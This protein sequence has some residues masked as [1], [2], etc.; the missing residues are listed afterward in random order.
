[1]RD[2]DLHLDDFQPAMAPTSVSATAAEAR[3]GRRRRQREQFIRVPMTW[4]RRLS[5]AG[6][7]ATSKVAL[8]LLDRAFRT[9]SS[10]IRL[11]NAGLAGVTRWQKVRAIEELEA[12]GL[13]KV[14]HRLR[15]SPEV[16]LLY[17]EG[18]K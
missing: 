18:D 10:T 11:T 5:D 15:K 7:V 13:I 14:E 17:P 16:T 6:C 3:A 1:M 2:D 8:H 9:H 4:A 12:L